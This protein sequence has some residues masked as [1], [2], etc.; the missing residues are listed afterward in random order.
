[1]ESTTFFFGL[2]GKAAGSGEGASG[3]STWTGNA[4]ENEESQETA[5]STGDADAK[6]AAIG[7]V[8]NN[9]KVEGGD[10]P[11]ENA[12]TGTDRNCT[13]W[14]DFCASKMLAGTLSSPVDLESW[15]GRKF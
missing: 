8:A 11:G 10:Y 4:A 7:A 3:T 1:M 6:D 15:K 14:C 2:E 9:E 5:I 13:R 12:T